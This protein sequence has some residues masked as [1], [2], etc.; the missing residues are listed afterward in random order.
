MNSKLNTIIIATLLLMSSVSLSGQTPE[1][2]KKDRT[3]PVRRTSAMVDLSSNYKSINEASS[4]IGRLLDEVEVVKNN[5]K[6][7]NES[8]SLRVSQKNKRNL[9]KDKAAQD[10]WDK[11]ITKENVSVEELV[12]LRAKYGNRPTYYVNGIEVGQDLMNKIRTSEIMTQEFRIADIDNGNPNGEKWYE[13]S[14]KVAERIGLATYVKP[15]ENIVNEVVETEIY[16]SVVPKKQKEET[17]V[18]PAPISQS[19]IDLSPVQEDERERTIVPSSGRMQSIAL[20]DSNNTERIYV[21]LER[22]NIVSATQLDM[23]AVRK[24]SE[25]TNDDR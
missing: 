13:V 10:A 5:G 19:K 2:E 3:V 12:E 16:R 22:N 21:S 15:E 6:S 7:R 25:D 14:S 4:D 1:N 24:S 17:H 9:K 20:S 11:L 8:L 23:D 18:V